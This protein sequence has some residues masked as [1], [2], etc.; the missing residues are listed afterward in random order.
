MTKH[1]ECIPYCNSRIRVK[2]IGGGGVTLHIRY[3]T[4]LSSQMFPNERLTP[5]T[6]I[7]TLSLLG[8][9]EWLNCYAHFVTLRC[10]YAGLG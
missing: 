6:L 5:E 3:K 10:E 7:K 2:F 1:W 4:R 8:Y 9:D